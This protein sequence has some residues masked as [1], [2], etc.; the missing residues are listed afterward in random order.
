MS[1]VTC[2]VPTYN[3]GRYLSEALDSIFA[4][5]YRPIDVIVADDGSSDDTLSVVRGYGD[6]IRMVTQ[7]TSG[8]AQT[9]N[10]GLKH[11]QTEFLA[12]LDADDL[13]HPEK[14][15]LQIAHFRQHPKLQICITHAKMFWSDRH[16][17]EARRY[18]DQPRGGAVPGYATTTLLAK[19]HVFDKVGMFNSRYWFSD[20]V[21]WFVRAK[22]L[23]LEVALLPDVLTFHRMHDQNLTRR[24]QEASRDE[25]LAL[26][27]ESI[28]F[29]KL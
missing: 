11:A 10:L 12:F 8:P 2:I 7:P 1:A 24:R 18:Q 3:S 15:T 25:F 17:D 29:H 23:G 28:E 26:A 5:S 22:R 21:E 16:N 19:R 27:K 14:L 4:Q 20:A 6:R 9:R 13:W